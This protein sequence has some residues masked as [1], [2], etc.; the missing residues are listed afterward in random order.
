MSEPGD[1][2]W[3][4]ATGSGAGRSGR[5][6]ASVRTSSSSMASAAFPHRTRVPT[7]VAKVGDRRSSVAWSAGCCSQ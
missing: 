6:A 1:P 2:A 4:Y 3:A 7:T 5:S